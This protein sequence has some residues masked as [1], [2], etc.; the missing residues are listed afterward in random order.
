MLDVCPEAYSCGARGPIWTDEVIPMEVGKMSTINSYDQFGSYCKWST[1]QLNVMR[2]SLDTD[3]DII[4]KY[5]GYIDGNNNQWY[6][7]GCQAAFCGMN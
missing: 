3:Y 6:D 5:T 1:Q 4:Y 7:S 2:C